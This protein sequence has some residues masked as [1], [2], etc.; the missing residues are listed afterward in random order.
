MAVIEAS[1]AVIGLVLLILIAWLVLTDPPAEPPTEYRVELTGPT[2]EGLLAAARLQQT[3]Q[4]LERQLYAEAA[5]HTVVDLLPSTTSGD[6]LRR[7]A[8]QEQR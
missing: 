6:E 3:A 5:R 7:L 1:L 2:L 8:E 4:E